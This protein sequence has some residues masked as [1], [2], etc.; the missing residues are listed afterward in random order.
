MAIDRYKRLVRKFPEFAYINLARQGLATSHYRLGNY[1]EASLIFATI[2]DAERTGELANVSYLLADCLIR[3]LPPETE[4][5]LQAEALIERAEQAAKLL[6]GFVGAQEK[7]PQAPD[8]LLKLG[9]CYQRV[10]ALMAAPAERTKMF[11]SAR[12]A[13]DRAIKLTDKEPTR[14]AAVFE[15]AKCLVFLGDPGGAQAALTQFQNGPLNATPN[16]PM[17]LLRL[18]TLLRAQ[19]KAAEAATMMAQCRATHEAKLA[20]DPARKH[21][22][23]QLQYEQALA[24]KESGKLPESRALFEALARNFAGQPEALN[25]QWRVGQCRREEGAAQLT[26]AREAVAKAGGKPELL[27]AAAKLIDTGMDAIRDAADSFQVDA[28]KLSAVPGSDEARRRMFY[29]GAWCYRLLAEAEGDAAKLKAQREGLDKTKPPGEQPP[30]ESKPPPLSDSEMRADRILS[31]LPSGP[32]PPRPRSPRKP[33]PSWPKSTART[34]RTTW[35]SSSLPRRWRVPPRPRS[36]SASGSGSRRRIS[37]ARIRSRRSRACSRCS[38]IPP[39]RTRPRRVPSPPRRS[40]SSRIGPRRSSSSSPSAT[41]RSSA[42][43]PA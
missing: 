27:A 11:T 3:T 43:S 4:D 42:A 32:P 12:D 26:A 31:A 22:V 1:T 40:C 24:V 19:S 35:R 23:P 21:W 18:S 39:A 16:A 41:T 15:R 8:A 20:S 5:A 38:R 13:Y 14:S 6:E 36:R 25:A 2:P 33:A 34:G 37:R 17:A 29:E 9:H 7:S 28:E 10:G 30:V